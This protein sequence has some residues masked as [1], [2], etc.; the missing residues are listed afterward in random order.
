MYY[1]RLKY[2]KSKFKIKNR[3]QKSIIDKS[4]EMRNKKIYLITVFYAFRF[5]CH[6]FLKIN[7]SYKTF[8]FFQNKQFLF[9]KFHIVKFA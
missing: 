3:T 2:L 7:T 1:K 5:A 9:K 6:Y 8:V 4:K